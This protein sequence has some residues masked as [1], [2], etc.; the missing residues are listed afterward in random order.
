MDAAGADRDFLATLPP[1]ARDRRLAAGV[2]VLSAAVFV[3]VAPFAKVPLPEVWPFIPTYESALAVNDLITAALLFGQFGILR[4]RSL[5]VLACGYL[6]TA[7]MAVSHTLTFPGVFSPPGLL[8]GGPQSTAWMWA[9]W[10]GGFPLCVVAYALLKGGSLDAPSPQG[11]PQVAVLSGVAAALA[12]MCG[13]T[14]LATAGDDAL[15]AIL[16]DNRYTPFGT[17]L[18]IGVWGLSVV[19]AAV[20]WRRRPHSVLDLWLLVAMIAWIFDI[21]LSAAFNAGR[22]DLGFYAGRIYGLLAA[23]F[24]LVVL[25]L[26]NGVLYARLADAYRR[27]QYT[28]A[29]EIQISERTRAEAEIRRVNAELEDRVRQRTADLAAA[30]HELEAFAYSVSHDLRA[31]LRAIDGFGGKLER[32][33]GERLDAEGRRLLH[34]VRDNARR[35]GLLI[36]DLLAFSRMGRREMVVAPVDMAGLARSVADELCGAEPP[37]RV[38]DI[39]IAD[40]PAAPGDGAMLRQVWTNLLSNALKF[41][42]P[43]HP[44]RIEIGGQQDGGEVRYW[45]RDNGVGF[46]PQYADK[47]FGVFQRLHAFDEFEGTGVGLALS[48]RIIHRHGGR[49]GAE[50]VVDGGAT[51]TFTLPVSPPAHEEMSR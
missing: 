48:Q 36:D 51:F 3:A 24:V 8:G 41:T 46:D 7:V 28:Q 37:A 18:L 20:L 11:R 33:Y 2:V 14:L 39:A 50:A 40:L 43:R 38:L 49:I 10:H 44:A 45:V 26:E 13:F 17:A 1:G 16:L 21:G 23:S 35:M 34:V 27:L 47:L 29:L 19:A 12:A 30:N 6:F 4:L 32:G 9:F 42:Q 31:P 15:P 25:L 22:F 5:W